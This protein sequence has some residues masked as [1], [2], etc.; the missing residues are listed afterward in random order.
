MMYFF[1]YLTIPL[2]QNTKREALTQPHAWDFL[3]PCITEWQDWAEWGHTAYRRRSYY[4]FEKYCITMVHV[5]KRVRSKCLCLPKKGHYS[6]F[7]T[8][9]VQLVT[10]V[11]CSVWI[12][13]CRCDKSI[14]ICIFIHATQCI[15]FVFYSCFNT[16]QIVKSPINKLDS[17]KNN[18]GKML[19]WL[20][21]NE[22][23]PV[24][25]SLLRFALSTDRMY[26]QKSKILI[27]RVSRKNI[28]RCKMLDLW[29]KYN[30]TKKRNV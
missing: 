7:R 19:Y 21:L 24:S 10:E 5:E 16:M 1:F 26:Y 15:T 30:S 27:R 17:T 9:V 6:L 22:H 28:M 13:L 29:W 25:S 14:Q 20:W 11:Q 2:K 12:R 3:L 4:L 18:L 8:P 23:V